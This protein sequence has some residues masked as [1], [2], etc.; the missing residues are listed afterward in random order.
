MKINIV[1]E[2]ILH[3]IN[4]ILVREI[5]R[6]FVFQHTGFVIGSHIHEVS[7]LLRTSADIEVGFLVER[8]IFEQRTI[9]VYIRPDIGIYPITGIL[10]LFLSIKDITCSFISYSFIIQL[11]VTVSV[12]KAR[13]FRRL[14]DIRF[15]THANNRLL[16]VGTTL[17]R[18][19][20]YTIGSTRTIHGSGSR[21][22]Q[23]RESFYNFRIKRIQVCRT[24]FHPI[25]NNKRRSHTTQSRNTTNVK[26]RTI[27]AR[28]SATLIGNNSRKTSGKRVRKIGRR[29][30]QVIRTNRLNR[31]HD[32]FFLLS[33]SESRNHNLS[34]SL[35]ILLHFNSQTL[36]VSHFHF[37]SLI[38]NIR[39]D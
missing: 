38:T 18:N 31:T 7:N 28:L 10:Y 32:R 16:K 15:H 36:L 13:H 3:Q 26:I 30:F 8:Q 23:N 34:Q 5:L 29:H 21:I 25:Q 6:C 39:E 22:F 1:L 24:H 11:H 27:T 17:G 37:L 33:G 14:C 2:G 4:I 20:H 12:Y 19:N 9:P 35:A